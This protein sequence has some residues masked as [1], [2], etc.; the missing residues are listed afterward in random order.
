MYCEIMSSESIK[1]Y[2]KIIKIDKK[3]F[4]FVQIGKKLFSGIGNDVFFQSIDRFVLF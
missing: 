1:R 3:S 2:K 4:H